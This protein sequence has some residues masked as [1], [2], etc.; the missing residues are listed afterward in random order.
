[1]LRRATVTST[2]GA[3]KVRLRARPGGPFYHSKTY[4]FQLW[5]VRAKTGPEPNLRSPESAR[6]RRPAEHSRSDASRR[7]LGRRRSTCLNGRKGR[8]SRGGPR[9]PEVPSRRTVSASLTTPTFDAATRLVDFAPKWEQ[10]EKRRRSASWGEAVFRPSF[11]G[12]TK[13]RVSPIS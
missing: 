1:M 7:R 12:P 8:F 9:G 11:Y 3:P 2:F 13:M 6:Y 5:P 10:E 4:F